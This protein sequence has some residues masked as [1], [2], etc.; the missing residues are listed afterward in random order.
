MWVAVNGCG[1]IGFKSRWIGGCVVVEKACGWLTGTNESSSE[2]A[3]EGLSGWC[4]IGE[5]GRN[6]GILL[7]K[8]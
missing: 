6:E 2:T 5:D 1:W 3:K 7:K 8:N 4:P